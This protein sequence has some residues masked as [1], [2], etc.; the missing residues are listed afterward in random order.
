[1]AIS[2]L[3][4]ALSRRLHNITKELNP[5]AFSLEDHLPFGLALRPKAQDALVERDIVAAD[6]IVIL[7][8]FSKKTATTPGSVIK[9]CKQRLDA[10]QRL[11]RKKG[12]K[13]RGQQ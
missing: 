12:D 11:A 1:V 13:R 4:R 6:A 10:Y 3:N 5:A 9:A 7:D 8:V 2:E